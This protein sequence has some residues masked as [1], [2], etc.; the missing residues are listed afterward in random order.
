MLRNLFLSEEF[1]SDRSR[2]TQIK[3][4]VQLVVGTLHD[5]GVKKLAR[6]DMLDHAIREM[7]QDLLEP[8]DVKGWRYGR[9]WISTSRL[10]LRYNLLA[11]LI[12]NAPRPDGAGVDL[13]QVLESGGCNTPPEIVEYLAKTCLNAPLSAEERDTLVASLSQLPPR[14]E[15]GKRRDE[16][17]RTL[18]QLLILLLST[19]EFQLT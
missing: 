3:C 17:N 16:A 7:G 5:L 2:G 11:D 15:W 18:R 6:Y 4:P 8:P 12:H 14:A 9:T 19:P 1:Y 10:F 13:V